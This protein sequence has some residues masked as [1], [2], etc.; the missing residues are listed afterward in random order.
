MCACVSGKLV[1]I[2]HYTPINDSKIMECQTL[3]SLK[4][5]EGVDIIRV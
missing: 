2:S 3:L 1:M 4:F 5:I